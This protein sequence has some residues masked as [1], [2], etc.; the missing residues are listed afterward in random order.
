MAATERTSFDG[1]L[2]RFM[3]RHPEWFG[4]GRKLTALE[5]EEVD[6]RFAPA[7]RSVA[8]MLEERARFEAAVAKAPAAEPVKGDEVVTA[9]MEKAPNEIPM[10]QDWEGAEEVSDEEAQAEGSAEVLSGEDF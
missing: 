2:A 7:P 6:W 1:F 4:D 3:A 8:E 10:F 5:R 9:V